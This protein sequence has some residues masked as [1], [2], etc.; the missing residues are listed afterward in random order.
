MDVQGGVF[1]VR[2]DPVAFRHRAGLPVV[3]ALLA[4]TQHPADHP[5]GNSV[6]G[7]IRGKR[8][9]HFGLVSLAK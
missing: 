3:V 1:H 8:V 7:K 6:G 4:E 9:D 5:Y 2:T